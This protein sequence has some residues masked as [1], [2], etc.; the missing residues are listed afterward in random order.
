MLMRNPNKERDGPLEVSFGAGR[1]PAAC[2]RRLFCSF[3]HYIGGVK[4]VGS[5]NPRCWLGDL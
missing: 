1:G 2:A 5:E 4:T 3:F